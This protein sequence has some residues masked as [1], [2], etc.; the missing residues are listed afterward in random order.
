MRAMGLIGGMMLMVLFVSTVGWSADPGEVERF[1]KA[2]IEIGE[3][4][5]NYFQSGESFGEGGRPSQERMQQMRH[6]INS[7][8]SAVLSKYDLTIDE[9]R[10][11]SKEVFGDE[12]AVKA[13]LDQHPD[14]KSRY[15]ALPLDRMGSG[16]SRRY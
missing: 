5:T 9:Y 14:L 2:R 11:R 1:V 16:G 13:F 10:G 12:A 6:D 4:M 15:E 7:K 3:M 8:L